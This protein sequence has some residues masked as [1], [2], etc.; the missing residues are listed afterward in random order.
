M[1]IQCTEK[2]PS[3]HSR[4]NF[5]NFRDWVFVVEQVLIDGDLAVSAWTNAAIIF[6]DWNMESIRL[7]RLYL[8]TP[9]DLIHA[10]HVLTERIGWYVALQKLETLKF[11]TSPRLSVNRSEKS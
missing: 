11:S 6:D 2:F 5:F 3:C 1:S 4:K 7:I 9:T 8:V 10:L